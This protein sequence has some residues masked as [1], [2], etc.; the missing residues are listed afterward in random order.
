MNVKEKRLSIRQT[1]RV[2]NPD[3]ICIQET[4]MENIDVSVKN[5]VCG[6]RFDGFRTIDARGTRGGLLIAW[7]QAK[8][9]EIGFVQ[10][11]FCLTL[12][13]KNT[14]DGS[15]F[16]ITGVYGPSNNNGRREFFEEIRQ[17]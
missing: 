11:N 16:T 12:R 6:R 9:E 1:F 10:G 8:F 7:S 3:F 13:L 14:Q 2:H 17:A 15:R 4:K 5:E